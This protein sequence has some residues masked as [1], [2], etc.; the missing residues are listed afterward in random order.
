MS[1][2]P[3]QS[4]NNSNILLGKTIEETYQKK[5]QL[6]HILLRPDTYIG[7]IDKHK[8]TLWVFQ[9]DEMVQKEIEYVP[10]LYKI[11]DEI[12]VNAADNKQRDPSMDTVKVEINVE[13]N[14]ISVY[15]TGN[16]VPVEIHKEE[17]I[18]VPEMIFGHLLTSSNYDDAEKKTTGG[19]NGYGAK[20]T[21]IF[22]TEFIIETADGTRLKKYKQVFS[23]NMAK[24]TEP[25]I[26]KCKANENWTKVTFKPD[27]EKFKMTE[28]EDD[29]VAL[30]KKRVIDIAGCLGKTVKV[31]LNGKQVPVKD[32]RDYCNLYL[33]SVDSIMDKGIEKCIM[34]K[35]N[36]RWEIC[37]SV[38]EEH[39]QQ[40]SFV[41]SIATIKGGTHVDHVTSQIVNHV[42]NEVNNKPLKGKDKN[43]KDL[44]KITAHAVKTHVWIFVNA[45]IDNPAFDSQTKETLTTRQSSF[46]S[47]CE[48][49]PAF[50]DKVSK[51]KIVEMVRSWAQHKAQKEKS[52]TDGKKGRL[53]GLAK[54][55]DAN[56]AGGK[57]SEECTL[58]LTEG[59]SAKTLAVAG[60]SVVGRNKF[61]VFPLRGKLLNVREASHKQIMD[62]VE[63]QSIKKI[64]G[65][66]QGK[67][68]ANVKDLR[69]GHLMIMT[70]QDHDGSHIKGLL[71]NFIHSFWPSLLQV[72]SFLIQFITPIVKASKGDNTLSFHTIPEFETWKEG[73]G[74]NVRSWSIKYYKGLGTSNEDE[75]REYFRN[76]EN[77]KKE[78]ELM[79]EQDGEAIEMAFSKKKIEARKNWLRQFEPGTHLDNSGKLIKYNDF[80][81]K[82]LI[83]FSIADLQRSIPSM[84]DGLKP[85]QRKTLFSAFKMNFVR[86]QKVSEFSGYVSANSAYHHGE[87]SLHGTI[88]GMAQD[89]VGS[90]NINLF[91]PSGQFGSRTKGGKDAASPRYINTRLCPLARLLFHKDDDGILDYLNEDGKSIE[92]FWYIPIIPMVLVNG[93]EGIGTGWSSYIPNYNPRDIVANIR[94]L[95]NGEEMQSM[96]PWYK[97]FRGT[98]E[99][100]ATKDSGATYTV[101]GIIEEISETTLRITELPIRRWTDEYK[102]FLESIEIG[103]DKSKDT[104]IERYTN[105]SDNRTVHYDVNMAEDKLLAAKQEGL[106]K[107]FKLTTSLSTS[108]MH[109]FDRKGV[110]KKYDSPEQILEEFFHLRLEYYEKRKKYLVYN[111]EKE[112]LKLE[113][114]VRFILAVVKGEIIVSNRKRMDLCQ[115]LRQNGYT[116]FPKK[117]KDTEDADENEESTEVEESKGGVRVSDYDYLLSMAIGSLTKEKVAE[118]LAAKSR[119]GVDVEIMK[120]TAPKTL[121]L[122]D[123]DVL[124]KGL[125]AQDIADA[126][127]EEKRIKERNEVMRKAG[128]DIKPLRK[129][130][131]KANVP[132]PA[133]PDNSASET[134]NGAPA[135]KPKGRGG[136]KK[137]L[138][139]KKK[140]DSDNEDDVLDLNERLANYHLDSSPSQSS[141]MDLEETIPEESMPDKDE[142]DEVI[143]AAPK[144][145][146]NKGR[147]KPAAVKTVKPAAATRKRGPAGNKQQLLSQ[148]LITDVL[149]PA[150]SS[151]ASPDKKVRK[152]RASPFNKKSSSVLGRI[153]GVSV[154]D[155]SGGSSSASGSPDGDCEIVTA[156][157]R[158]QRAN[159]RIAT[160]VLSD[161]EPD[162][163]DSEFDV[164]EIDDSDD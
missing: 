43:K 126:K 7:S 137:D 57:N 153:D 162:T 151:G 48:L 154:E 88:I 122:R 29:V 146:K 16:G 83:L 5:S 95:I 28:L 18:Y 142:I 131:K 75:A 108:N 110:I 12:L 164:Q 129:K 68:Y 115:E 76:I 14:C 63:I 13:E 70:D 51:S 49:S 86:E 147:K 150:Q 9:D 107:K 123:L 96:S 31:F 78:F 112:Q 160:Y 33:K 20:L 125:D 133:K 156:K 140:V 11:F 128:L 32:F 116:P 34:E 118:L 136:P 79:D 46:G 72:P 91:Y 141:A 100:T 1:N 6:E 53:Y 130:A 99:K 111:L 65:L 119:M 23:N 103:N 17:K 64:L 58:I 47:K 54:L 61:G 161:S 38:S 158:P 94:H 157:A 67:Q 114:K 101:N 138:A 4:S 159:R 124:E 45:L 30:M 117:P 85:G 25:T 109:L 50:L 145:G 102:E 74:E 55:E 71:I 41:N 19:R 73:L 127:A 44:A 89:F 36:E 39:F 87:Q 66:Q 10:G 60:L 98:I 135:E 3:L 106:L 52:K 120:N 26:T 143:A 163:D 105:Q 121:W 148:K 81:N 40:V 59:D 134:G 90:N 56:L 93:S 97:G 37:F 113:N 92:P 21:N 155:Q 22:S 104:F 62:N 35:A 80:V 69:Y 27:L 132:A 77:N 139:K 2:L 82:E 149:K 84:V 24:K 42:M 144:E 8:Q 15:N 152:I